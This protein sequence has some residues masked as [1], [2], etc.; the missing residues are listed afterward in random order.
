MLPSNGYIFDI[1]IGYEWNDFMEGIALNEDYGTYGSVLEPNNTS[2]LDLNYK[3]FNYINKYNISV[4]NSFRFAYIGNDNADDFFYFFGGGMP[5]LKG[6]TFYEESLTGRGLIT[7]SIYARKLIM[8][9]SFFKFQDF[10]A[11]NKLSFGIA[12]QYGE[13]IPINSP[14]FSGGLEL[15]AKGFLFY[16]YPAAITLEYHFPIFDDE[17]DSSNGKT[18]MKL[19]FDF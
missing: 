7:S 18:Y 12:A 8:N 3:L 1:A 4:E 15:R 19:L 11:L 17:I 10:I 9:K 16:G 6:Y 14:K 2:R 5:G 13:A